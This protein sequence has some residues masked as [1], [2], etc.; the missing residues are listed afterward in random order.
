M[1][2]RNNRT[3][4]K[5]LKNKLRAATGAAQSRF[6]EG[7]FSRC[8]DLFCRGERVTQAT[9][10]QHCSHPFAGSGVYGAPIAHHHPVLD[11][12]LGHV[13][14]S[15][16][17][18]AVYPHKINGK[19]GMG[20][21]IAQVAAAYPAGALLAVQVEKGIVVFALQAL[22]A[23]CAHLFINPVIMERIKNTHAE[24][25]DT[26]AKVNARATNG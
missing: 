23:G 21:K 26:R 4:S 6:R 7:P 19:M 12:E 17:K 20:G 9:S 14:P 25:L 16:H 18:L 13:L 11:A 22:D 5:N 1:P 8:K 10:F 3:K 24:G 15:Y 2:S